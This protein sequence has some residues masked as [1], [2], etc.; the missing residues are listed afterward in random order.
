MAVTHEITDFDLIEL[1]ERVADAPA[2]ARG[3]VLEIRPDG[4]AM[5]EILEPELGAAE[6]IVF[7]PLDKMRHSTRPPHH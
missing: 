6:R 5:V 3:G 7:A 4:V 2:G 1:T